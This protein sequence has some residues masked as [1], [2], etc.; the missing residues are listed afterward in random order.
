M[1]AF[2]IL[3]S[4]IEFKIFPSPTLGVLNIDFGDLQK[5]EIHILDIKG[6]V[7]DILSVNSNNSQFD[8]SDYSSGAYHIK[9]MPDNVIYPI[10]KQ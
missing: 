1:R 2:S 7:L 10:V 9:I 6:T 5:R 4:V 8:I 3:E